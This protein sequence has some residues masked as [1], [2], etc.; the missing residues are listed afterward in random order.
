MLR[1]QPRGEYKTAGKPSGDPIA[2]ALR[3]GWEDYRQGV[4]SDEY[5]EWPQGRQINYEA[6]RRAAAALSKYLRRLPKWPERKPFESITMEL[7]DEAC[8]AFQAEN[9]LTAFQRSIT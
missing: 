6:G 3:E 9:I 2:S 4:Y 5:D 7:S 1:N 8:A